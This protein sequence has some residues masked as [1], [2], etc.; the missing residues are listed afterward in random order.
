MH[1][2]L[3]NDW[4]SRARVVHVFSFVMI[5]NLPKPPSRRMDVLQRQQR[6]WHW[7]YN[8][9]KQVSGW[10]R[11]FLLWAMW[12]K[13]GWSKVGELKERHENIQ[14]GQ[15]SSLFTSSARLQFMPILNSRSLLWLLPSQPE[16]FLADISTHSTPLYLVNLHQQ[17]LSISNPYIVE[18][19]RFRI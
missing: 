12:R 16:L 3:R 10:R 18:I 17:F 2:K 4:Y 6:T 5:H 1:I 19:R 7:I 14:I 13:R 11:A 15:I 9:R 8:Q